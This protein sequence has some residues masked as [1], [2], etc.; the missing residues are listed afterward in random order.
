MEN[1]VVF[2][3]HDANESALD[4]LTEILLDLPLDGRPLE[5]LAALLLLIP[6][7]AD[8]LC[9]FDFEASGYALDDFVVYDIWL[10]FALGV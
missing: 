2:E 10:G 4:G 1:V 9:P 5:T 7:E 8:I 6:K 3:L